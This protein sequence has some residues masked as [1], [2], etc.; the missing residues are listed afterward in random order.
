[1][2]SPIDKGLHA[3]ALSLALQRRP[4]P[5][6]TAKG[7]LIA[8][9][10]SGDEAEAVIVHGVSEGMFAEIETLGTVFLGTMTSA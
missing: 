1:M 10:L 7:L 9:G 3:A 4:L 8:M 6:T 5:R 2:L